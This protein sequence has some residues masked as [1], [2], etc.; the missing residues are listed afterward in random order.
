M[1]FA[2]LVCIGQC[3]LV[4]A[5]ESLWCWCGC[6]SCGWWL[7]VPPLSGWVAAGNSMNIRAYVKWM[8]PRAKLLLFCSLALFCVGPVWQVKRKT[9]IQLKKKSTLWHE[10][11]REFWCGCP[12]KCSQIF[13]ILKK[14]GANTQ[15][16]SSVVQTLIVWPHLNSRS[17]VRLLLRPNLPCPELGSTIFRSCC[18]NFLLY[19]PC[20]SS[21]SR[22]SCGMNRFTTFHDCNGQVAWWT[23]VFRGELSDCMKLTTSCH[24]KSL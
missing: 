23:K 15:M 22:P 16:K 14:N 13:S 11:G 20:T 21:V 2:V 6:S 24:T 18:M 17:Q 7:W 10:F 1:I 3:C 9:L 19:F 5:A 8:L 12:Q 4:L